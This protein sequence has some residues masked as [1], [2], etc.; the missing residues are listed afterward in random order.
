M[1]EEVADS[2]VYANFGKYDEFSK[3]Q[4]ELLALDPNADPTPEEE[5]KEGRML[6]KLLAILDEYQEQPYL[7]DPFLSDLVSPVVD[8]IKA[9]A[10]TP[11]AKST[12]RIFRLSSLLYHYVKFRGSKTITRFFPHEVPDLAI[13][14]DYMT[15]E[16]SPTQDSA[17]WALRYVVLLWLSLICMI[18]FD[19]AQFDEEGQV[20]RTADLLDT[21]GKKYVD[22][23]GLEREGA[24]SLLARLYMRRDMLHRFDPFLTSATDAVNSDDVFTSLG[25]LQVICEV[26]K[27]GP[28]QVIR[29]SAPQLLALAEAELLTKNMLLRKYKTK[30][31]ARVA[32]RLLPPRS[33]RKGT[34]LGAEGQ[35][36]EETEPEIDVP[37]EVETALEQLFGSLQ[38]KDTVVR[39]SAAKGV[40][41]IAERLPIDFAEQVLETVLGLFAIHSVASA[42]LYDVPTVAEGTWH[43]AC[44][45][46]AEMARRGL[47][48]ADK[49]PELIGWLDKALYFD[50]RKGAHSVGSN[51]RDSASYVLWAL[52][53]AHD[54]ALLAPHALALARSLVTVA[55]YDREISIRRA[56]SAAF[57]EF[58]GR[59]GLFPHG[60][61]VLRKTDFYAVS[62]R[63]NAFLVAAPETAE[64]PEYRIFLFDHLLDVTLRHWDPSMRRLGSQSLRLLCLL[65]LDVLGPKAVEKASKL[66]QA[67]DGTDIHGGLLALSEVAA[68]YKERYSGSELESR[69]R[70]IFSR[71]ALVKPATLTAHRNELIT[72]EACRLIASTLTLPEVE[73]KDKGAVP[74]WRKVVE[75]GL[76]HRSAAVQDEAAAA[77]AALSGLVDCSNTVKRLIKDLKT[78]T[79]SARPTLGKMLGVLRY[80]KH[81]NALKEVV[82]CLL[83]CV[84]ASSPA[85][86][87]VEARK[88]C[89]EAI[90]RVLGTVVDRLPELLTP[91]EVGALE[92]A[93]LRGLEDYTMDER[94]DVGSWIRI[95][96]I[97]GLRDCAIMLLQ[98]PALLPSYLRP[99]VYH[100][101]VA[102]ILKQGVERLDNVRAEAGAC[103]L[104]LLMISPPNE[105]Y[106][107][108][109]GD[110]MRR[111]FLQGEPVPWSDGAVFFPK[112]ATLLDVARYR[113]QVLSGMILSVGS[114]SESI[115][116][117]MGESLAGYAA[118]LPVTPK[119]SVPYSLYEL[120]Q[121]VLD[122]GKAHFTSNMVFV[123]VLQT[124][125]VLL[126]SEKLQDALSDKDLSNQL[127]AIRLLATK[128]ITR[129]KNVQRI[130]ESMKIVVNLLPLTF[131][132]Q[133]DYVLC[134]EALTFFLTHEFPHIRTASAEY[135]C[136]LLPGVDLE[137]REE[138]VEEVLLE[139]E[140]ISPDKNLLEDAKTR[141]IAALKG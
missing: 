67:V 86:F 72:A 45:A 123:P 108:E 91:E 65:D 16:G 69:L 124:L 71:L 131:S 112:A 13:A 119:D 53:R 138:A 109:G 30:L 1:S 23:A 121:D 19:L 94:G 32:L 57:Q 64:H 128:N 54:A 22:R 97:Q 61:D 42:S 137:G 141:V 58:V 79:M 135:M 120:L 83:E 88:T 122:H 27:S 98:R 82:E 26:V 125:N 3:T 93:L 2:K 74:H 132:N 28:E 92:Q 43:G 37:E 99:D 134:V 63:K 103:M 70:E 48:T 117:P 12:T 76:C 50:L 56:A 52:A 4:A 104:G 60:I 21:L 9:H 101:A 90:S 77:M 62:V 17:Q 14:I 20:G 34:Q 75:G 100:A 126:S 80:D 87:H 130:Q 110:A 46:C 127:S 41:R 81:A 25:V 116:R 6:G 107:I 38:D 68:A 85:K 113:K 105:E 51:V 8:A 115:T 59:T 55:V 133:E 84:D 49:L 10:R 73:L 66:L 18:P 136:Q 39:W 35:V 36:E 114:R 78:T 40:A 140:W 31:V 29:K 139:T 24:A 95:S 15:R 96:S 33:R 102:G 89:Y 129:L 5:M 7:A 111:M 11:A 47:V 118:S 44:L 106:A